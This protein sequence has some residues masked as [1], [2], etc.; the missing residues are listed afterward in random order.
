MAFVAVWTLT[1]LDVRCCSAGGFASEKRKKMDSAGDKRLQSESQTAREKK[2]QKQNKGKEGVK[3]EI[4][5]PVE[6][7]ERDPMWQRDE[8]KLTLHPNTSKIRSKGSSWMLLLTAQPSHR[9][10]A[11]NPPPKNPQKTLGFKTRMCQVALLRQSCFC[12]SKETSSPPGVE[13]RKSC[14]GRRGSE[15]S[16]LLDDFLSNTAAYGPTL[17]EFSQRFVPL[18]ASP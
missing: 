5:Q 10:L 7:K 16:P 1:R 6:V 9:P 2:E 11:Q 15:S 13:G 3:G 17:G 18:G 4:H 8:A 14:N 12:T